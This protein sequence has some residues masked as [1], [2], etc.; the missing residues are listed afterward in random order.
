[1]ATHYPYAGADGNKQGLHYSG[2]SG[3]IHR[4]G[5]DSQ[6]KTFSPLPKSRANPRSWAKA[7]RPYR[8]QILLGR[9]VFKVSLAPFT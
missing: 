2:F 5:I 7:R 9:G 1:M 3:L 6:G 4:P 8:L